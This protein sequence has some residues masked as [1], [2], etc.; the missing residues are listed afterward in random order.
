MQQQN[1]PHRVLAIKHAECENLGHFETVLR[2]R[3]IPYEYLD[4]ATE[5]T[6]P[7]PVN[8]FYTHLIVLGGF[9]SVYQQ[10]EYPWLRYECKLI[11]D[12]L[13]REVPILGICLGAQ[14][15]AKVLGATV[16]KGDR[17]PELG[18]YDLS[19]TAAGENDPLFKH[20][21]RKFKALEWHGD[22]FEMPPD[23]VRLAASQQYPNQAFRYGDRVWGL[24]FHLEATEEIVE[25][26]V[27][28]HNENKPP[29]EKLPPTLIRQ[30]N[31]LY[32]PNFQALSSTFLHQ[33]FDY[34]TGMAS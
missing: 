6:F 17:G 26:W 11:E 7:M 33:F 16:S 1:V 29:G 3:N 18:W 14:L 25:K 24:Q 34:T 12:A 21:P 5:A 9:M 19:V 10:K 2:D 31:R 4:M 30:A 27:Q 32:F 20:F 13:H 8:E 28:N 15:V 23:C 22:C